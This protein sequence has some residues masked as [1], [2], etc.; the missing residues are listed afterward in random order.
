MFL[1]VYLP[2]SI[3]K[4]KL[5]AEY[6]KV[7]G[8]GEIHYNTFRAYW[9]R[10]APEVIV[11]KP[12]TDVCYICDQHRMNI[13]SA[14]TAE[15]IEAA[16]SSLTRHLKHAQSERQYYNAIIEDARADLTSATPPTMRHITFDFAQQLELPQHT[17]QVGPLYFKSRFR[18]QLFGVCDEAAH[19]QVNFVFHEGETI[20]EDGKKAHGPNAVIS[21]LHH[22]MTRN[23]RKPRLWC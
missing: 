12:R 11:M 14:R 16:S 15:D 20:G 13:R 18:V 3:N 22:Y 9:K 4:R 5:F 8:A 19:C 2:A 1:P 21:M 10:L 17:R 23:L 7:A 6:E